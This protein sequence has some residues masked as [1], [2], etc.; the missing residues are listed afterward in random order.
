MGIIIGRRWEAAGN[1]ETHEGM[2]LHAS[3]S[4]R[5]LLPAAYA[6][7]ANTADIRNGSLRFGNTACID[8]DLFL[9]RARNKAQQSSLHT[10]SSPGV[11][12]VAVVFWR[13]HRQES[14]SA[15]IAESM[16]QIEVY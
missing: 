13:T 7:P 2:E 8:H 3:R 16:A 5:Q 9:S 4:S 15:Q 6:R 1:Q 10:T 11:S 12:I 14:C